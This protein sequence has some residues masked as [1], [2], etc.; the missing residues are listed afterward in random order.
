MRIGITVDP[1][2]PVPPQHYGGIERVVA[3]LVRELRKRGH[4][5]TLFAHPDSDVADRLVPYGVP[6]HEGLA[7]RTRELWQVGSVVW[8]MRGQFDLVHSFGRLAALLPVLGSRR[9]AKIQSY[10][11]DGIPWRSVQ[12]A[13]VLAG[14][15]ICFTAC[16][17]RM[18][19]ERMQQGA[20]ASQWEVI[21]NGVDL[22]SYEFKRSVAPDAPLVFL[23]R[24]EPIKGAHHAIQIAYATGKKLVIAGNQVKSCQDYFAREIAPHIDGRQ[25][26]YVGPVDDQQKNLLLG[27]AR[28]F[29]MPIDWEEPFGI[30]MAEALACGTPVIG[31]NRGSVPEVIQDGTNGYICRDVVEASK[32]VARLDQIDRAEVRRDC[33]SRFSHTVIVDQYEHLYRRMVTAHR[34]VAA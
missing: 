4:E 7:R 28:A 26:Q 21:F 10:Q 5:V 9:L 14:D 6:P 34:R 13:N 33:E 23:G 16:S 15:S 2:L 20:V 24:L 8:K 3:F 17:A 12:V 27:S 30:V 19:R 22:D 11:R 29:L 18:F 32:A 31:F 1:Y 25:I